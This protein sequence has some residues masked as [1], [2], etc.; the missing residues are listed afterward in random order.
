MRRHDVERG[1]L[2]LVHELGESLDVHPLTDL[3]E[4]A[5]IGKA[6]GLLGR[7]FVGLEPPDERRGR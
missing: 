6:D 4:A 5:Q 3:R 2:E 1:L 7:G